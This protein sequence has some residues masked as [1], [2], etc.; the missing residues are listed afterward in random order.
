MSRS[1]ELSRLRVVWGTPKLE[2]GVRSEGGLVWRLHPLNFV[3][4]LTDLQ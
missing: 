1:R 2:V 4:G 3:A